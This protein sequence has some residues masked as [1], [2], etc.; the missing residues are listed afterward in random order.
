[1]DLEG[2]IAQF[3][4]DADDTVPNPY[5]WESEWVAGWL[6][7]AQAEAAIRGRLLYE[8]V[9]PA[10]CEI[11]VVAG[12]AVYALHKALYEIGHLRFLPTGASRSEPVR[13][14]TRGELDRIC[15]DWREP[16]PGRRMEFA[17]QDDT[18]IQLVSKPEYAGTLYLE[19]WR[20]PLKALEDDGDKPEVNEAHHRHLVQWALH[21]AFSKP[22]SETID[23]KRAERAEFEFTRYFGQRPDAG[24]RRETQSDRPQHNQAW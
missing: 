18:R 16:I 7:E 9:N 3:R 6:S 1:M 5:L 15:P 13:L 20:L 14:T 21:R 4:V 22:D 23:P 19:G 24:L 12:T 17:I 11:P 10:I 8:S 2:L